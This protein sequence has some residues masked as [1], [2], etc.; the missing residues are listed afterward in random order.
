MAPLDVYVLFWCF[1]VCTSE[2]RCVDL[3]FSWLLFSTFVSTQFKPR[4]ILCSVIYRYT[5]RECFVYISCVFFLLRNT[6][7]M[8]TVLEIRDP[9]SDTTKTDSARA[10]H[11]YIRIY[12]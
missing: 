2:R 8:A 10:Q 9:L 6:I 7:K 3:G 11:F 5:E 4:N 12:V 1:V